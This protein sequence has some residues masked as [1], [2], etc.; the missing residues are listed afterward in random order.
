MA[1]PKQKAPPPPPKAKDKPKKKPPETTA[2]T[3]TAT[4]PTEPTTPTETTTKLKDDKAK[5][6]QKPAKTTKTLQAMQT[7]NS[8][9]K[10][11][12][13]PANMTTPAPQPAAYRKANVTAQRALGPRQPS[14]RGGTTAAPSSGD[15]DLLQ[16]AA[17]A[18]Q[19]N[20]IQRRAALVGQGAQ[21]LRRAT[22]D[23]AARAADRDL[24]RGTG[25]TST[26]GATNR[27]RLAA[28]K[29]ALTKEGWRFQRQKS[30]FG[31]PGRVK[32]V[33]TAAATTA[34]VS[35]AP[36]LAPEDTADVDVTL[37]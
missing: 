24:M 35:T 13:R 16:K 29:E 27:A 20:L 25:A 10:P 7:A 21:K 3:P 6:T 5:A 34:P 32:P 9:P 11:P 1:K 28:G 37:S 19:Q 22:M 18:R 4:T 23:P 2:G 36:V 15:K 33:A 14:H 26:M 17:E 30:G 31:H 12:K 8:K